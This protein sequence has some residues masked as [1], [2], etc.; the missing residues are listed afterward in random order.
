MTPEPTTTTPDEDLTAAFTTLAGRPYRHLPVVEGG[1][2]VGIISIR[3]LTR[4]ARIQPVDKPDIEVPRGLKG[5]VVAETTIGDVRG[6]EGFY[7]Y[8]Q[9]SAIELNE[10]RPL[11]DV[12]HLMFEGALPSLAQRAAFAAETR[13]LRA[14]PPALAPQVCALTPTL[15]TALYRLN[16]GL[17]PVEPHPDLPYAANYLYMLT[18]E[19]PTA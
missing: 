14:I 12:W 2:L 15:L 18:G 7:H 6:Q 10:Q 3:D 1:E 19:E 11:E 5:V 17:A 4:L 8:R 16:K 13:P 9:Y